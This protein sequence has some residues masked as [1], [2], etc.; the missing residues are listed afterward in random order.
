M[1]FFMMII[2]DSITD[3]AKSL[4]LKDGSIMNMTIHNRLSWGAKTVHII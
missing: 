4:F 3:T 2:K 1:L